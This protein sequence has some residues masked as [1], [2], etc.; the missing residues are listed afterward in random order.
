M[1]KTKRTEEAG[2]SFLCPAGDPSGRCC[3]LGSPYSK[4]GTAEDGLLHPAELVRRTGRNTVSIAPVYGLCNAA[5][6]PRLP[7]AIT[8]R[9]QRTQSLFVIYSLRGR[10][11]L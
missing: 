11:H 5:I 7:I 4:A 3:R 1:G 10:P 8:A 6:L 2:S 9:G